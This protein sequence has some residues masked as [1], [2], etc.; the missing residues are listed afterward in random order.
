MPW[1]EG[2]SKYFAPSGVRA[3]G[4]CPL[5]GSALE[6]VTARN[7]D[8]K[9]LAGNDDDRVPWHFKLLVALLV[10]YMAWRLIDLFF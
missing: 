10:A 6:P 1:C 5:C 2:C 3:D 7:L 8:L 9:K 4:S